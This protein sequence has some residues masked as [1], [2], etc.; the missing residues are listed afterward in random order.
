MSIPFCFSLL[1]TLVVAFGDH[2]GNPRHTTHPKT[3]NSIPSAK[4]PFPNK[5]T[6]TGPRRSESPLVAISSP[7]HH[8]TSE[9]PLPQVTSPQLGRDKPSP[10]HPCQK[11]KIHKKMKNS[12]CQ[13]PLSPRVACYTARDDGHNPQWPCPSVVS[14]PL[15]ISCSSLPALN[16]ARQLGGIRGVCHPCPL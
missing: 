14:V 11:L 13:K 4:T 1:M 12:F 8:L 3:L 9:S 5:V 2:P 16:P 10:P 7:P 6:V 15:Q